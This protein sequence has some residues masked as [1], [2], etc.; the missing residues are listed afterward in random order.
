VDAGYEEAV[1]F[2]DQKGIHVPLMNTPRK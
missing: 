1:R 2:A